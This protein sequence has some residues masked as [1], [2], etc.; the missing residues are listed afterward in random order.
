M[1]TLHWFLMGSN[2]ASFICPESARPQKLQ[3]KPAHTRSWAKSHSQNCN[4]LANAALLLK[5]H[6]VLSKKCQSAGTCVF[7]RVPLT[8]VVRAGSSLCDVNECGSRWDVQDLVVTKGNADIL[9]ASRHLSTG[10]LPPSTHSAFVN[11]RARAQYPVTTLRLAGEKVKWCDWW[12][13]QWNEGG[14]GRLWSK[15]NVGG[16]VEKD[17]GNGYSSVIDNFN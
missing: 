8:Q 2:N 7:V 6:P 10:A 3:S 4:S 14:E 9:E 15:R 17:V 13:R 5:L 16:R 12:V 1:Y 11:H